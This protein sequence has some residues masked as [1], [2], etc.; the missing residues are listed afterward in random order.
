MIDDIKSRIVN[1]TTSK[2]K[3]K[4]RYIIRQALVAAAADATATPIFLS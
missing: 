1:L 4:R 2:I 3:T